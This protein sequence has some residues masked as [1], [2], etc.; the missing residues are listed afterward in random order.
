MKTCTVDFREFCR[1]ARAHP[2]PFANDTQLNGMTVGLV[3]G[4]VAAAGVTGIT[5]A[6]AERWAAMTDREDVAQLIVML[7]RVIM[8]ATS[9]VGL[10]ALIW[11]N[12]LL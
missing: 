1:P 7:M 8:F 6:L 12:P 5:A 11:L 3:Y 9:L 10:G 2:Q 4:I